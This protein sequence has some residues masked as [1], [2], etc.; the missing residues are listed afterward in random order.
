MPQIPFQISAAAARA[1]QDGG[2]ITTASTLLNLMQQVTAEADRTEL[3]SPVEQPAP[4]PPSRLRAAAGLRGWGDLD[5]EQRSR[6]RKGLLIGLSVG[7][8]IIV[9]ALMILAWALKGLFGDVGV[10]TTIN[11]PAIGANSPTPGATTSVTDVKPLRATVFSPE[12]VAD[13]PG[14]AGLAIDGNPSTAW[15][16]DTYSDSVPF[17]GF[18][19]GVGLM[20]QLPE[21]TKL[22]AVNVNLSSTGTRI[23]IR[24]ATTDSPA[25]LEDTTKLTDPHRY[26]P[27]RTGSPSRC[28]HRPPLCWCGSQ[29]W[30]APTAKAVPTF[31]KS[32]LNA[33][34]DTHPKY[35]RL[36]TVRKRAVRLVPGAVW[37]P[38][39]PPPA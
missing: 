32:V 39:W 30:V 24:S 9:V 2:G 4:R 18:K 31:T 12:G 14:T 15:S 37:W 16:T 26:S 5:E 13:N 34:P 22:S 25:S 10:N 38:R 21:P 20:L 27:D 33:P 8:A 28:R 17:P 29:R 7:G 11:A 23:Q 3:I 6:R 1:V 19:N 35:P 36:V